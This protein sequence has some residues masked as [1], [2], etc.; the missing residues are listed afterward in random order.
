MNKIEEKR[1][2]KISKLRIAVAIF[3]FVIPMIIWYLE[4]NNVINESLFY[5]LSFALIISVFLVS[6]FFNKKIGLTKNR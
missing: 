5:V 6:Y 1:P 4:L 3:V 2:F